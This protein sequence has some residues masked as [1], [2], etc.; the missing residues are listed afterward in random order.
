MR[1]FASD[2]LGRGADTTVDAPADAIANSTVDVTAI[3]TVDATI[4]ATVNGSAEGRRRKP[5][6]AAAHPETSVSNRECAG[7]PASA[8]AR[9]NAAPLTKKTRWRWSLRMNDAGRRRAPSHTQRRQWASE[10]TQ[11]V[12]RLPARA[13]IRR[14]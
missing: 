14:R 1:R 4:N 7:G 11:G 6:R 13:Q 2:P 3:A 10:S 9:S 5:M 8:G 12:W